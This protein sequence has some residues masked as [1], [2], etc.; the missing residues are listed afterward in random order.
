MRCLH[1]HP[2]VLSPV[3]LPLPSS[4]TCLAVPA[5]ALFDTLRCLHTDLQVLSLM[6]LRTTVNYQYRYGKRGR[7]RRLAM[8]APG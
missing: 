2:Q 1:T 7:R 5:G 8:Q 3:C 4:T 6:W